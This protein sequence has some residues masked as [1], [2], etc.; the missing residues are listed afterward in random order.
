[1]FKLWVARTFGL[2]LVSGVLA[3]SSSSGA[4]AVP[5][6]DGGVVN[7]AASGTEGG[8]PFSIMGTVTFDI[9]VPLK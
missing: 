2:A 4:H 8:V 5:I 3:A 9:L 1:M 7:I 6:V